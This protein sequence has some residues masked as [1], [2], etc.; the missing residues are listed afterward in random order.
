VARAG[1]E[2]SFACVDLRDLPLQILSRDRPELQ[3]RPLAV[4]AEDRP[5]AVLT[6]VDSRARKLRLAPGMRYGAAKNL[7]PAL[8]A[9]TVAPERIEAILRELVVALQAFSPRVEVDPAR[10]GTFYVDPSGLGRIYGD[11]QNWAK[12]V[13]A[14]F[15][16]RGFVAS[17]VVARGRFASFAIARTTKGVIVLEGRTETRRRLEGVRLRDLDLTPR[18]RDDL[19]ALS[20]HTLGD[21]LGLPAGELH[22]RFGAEAARLQAAA[23][24][25]AQLPMQPESFDEPILVSLELDPPDDDHS[26]LLFGIKGALHELLTHVASRGVALSALNIELSLEGG[27]SHRERIEPAAPTRDAMSILDLVR[28][29][30]ADVRL[31]APAES[32]TLRAETAPVDGDQLTMFQMGPRRDLAAGE[33][34]LARVRAAFGAGSVSRARLRDAHLPEARFAWEPVDRLRLSRLPA[35][36]ET[37][38]GDAVPPLVRRVLCRPRPLPAMNRAD[39]SAG[40]RLE[41]GEA[42]LRLFG[43]YRVSGG[44]WVRNVE[45]DYYYAETAGGELLWL[46][47]DRPRKRWFLHGLVD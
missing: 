46:F 10:P 14:Y 27:A 24:D 45:R 28:L 9:A 39:P 41:N 22:A 36:P 3:G 8:R 42:V 5:D 15:R 29:R 19:G 44:W 11:A 34:A 18:L 1:G 4:V 16:G 40:P 6:H 23:E 26:R 2:R 43:P 31:S 12:A 13:R 38:D 25:D 17:V 33:R 20:V 47:W 37:L 32:I 35:R 30:L 7:V 21:L